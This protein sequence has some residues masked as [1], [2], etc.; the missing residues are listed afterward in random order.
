MNC[1]RWGDSLSDAQTVEEH[2]RA[3]KKS[4]PRP[5]E[6]NGLRG[7]RRGREA[8]FFGISGPVGLDSSQPPCGTFPV[9]LP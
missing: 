4:L 1:R 5:G 7:I 2:P 3:S 8:Y 6:M 9:E